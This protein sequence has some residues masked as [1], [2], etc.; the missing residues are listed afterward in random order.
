MNNFVVINKNGEYGVEKKSSGFGGNGSTTLT[1]TP[2]INSATVFTHYRY[3]FV[4]NECTKDV[5]AKLPA[6]EIRVVE[7]LGEDGETNN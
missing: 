2:D 5:V 7:L 6:K 4:R 1:F 3:S